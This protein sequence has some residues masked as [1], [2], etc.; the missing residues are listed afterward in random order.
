MSKASA[1][2]RFLNAA[3]H[4]DLIAVAHNEHS[5]TYQNAKNDAVAALD[6]ARKAGASQADVDAAINARH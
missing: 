3:D 4:V 6:Q 2:S 5:P 1:I